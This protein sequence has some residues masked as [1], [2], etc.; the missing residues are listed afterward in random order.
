MKNACEIMSEETNLIF[1]II[2]ISP[3]FLRKIV[4]EVG[5][6]YRL[7]PKRL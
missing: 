7:F 2:E 6:P 3:A 1:F 4:I 5:S